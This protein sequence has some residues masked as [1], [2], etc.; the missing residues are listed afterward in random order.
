[1]G[2]CISNLCCSGIN[3]STK[4]CG[5][6]SRFSNVQL[7]VALRTVAHQVPLYV[8]FSRQE[9]WSGLPFPSPGDLPTCNSRWVLLTKKRCT[10]WE[11]WVKFYLGQNEDCH[12]GGSNSDSSK[13]LLQ[14][15][16]GGKSIYKVLAKGE[17]NTMKH[18]FYK[19]FFFFL[20]VMRIWCHQEGS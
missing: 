18:S 14:S 17:F 3:C 5:M 16:S 12:P 1:M 7:C 2:P 13:R 4:I 11:V 19:R 10:T 20:L 15:G 8:R 6:L 9:Y